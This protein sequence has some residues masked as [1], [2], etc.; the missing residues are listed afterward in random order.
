MA[1]RYWPVGPCSTSVGDDVV[2]S[3]VDV[4]LELLLVPVVSLALDDEEDELEPWS[5][6]MLLPRCDWCQD[7][8]SSRVSFWSLL[9]SIALK[10]ADSVGAAV[11]NS[12]CDR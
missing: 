2:S 10:L 6:S 7:C 5:A 1:G 11:V 9:A 12:V 4:L 8:N 3:V